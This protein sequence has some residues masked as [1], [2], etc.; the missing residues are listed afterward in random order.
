MPMRKQIKKANG[1]RFRFDGDNL[2]TLQGHGKDLTRFNCSPIAS[3]FLN[4]IL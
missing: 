3:F 1:F 4:L 2:L